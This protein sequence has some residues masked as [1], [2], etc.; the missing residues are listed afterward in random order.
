MWNRLKHHLLVIVV[1]IACVIA[2]SIVSVSKGTPGI[3]CIAS[4]VENIA[5]S[6]GTSIKSHCW[7]CANP[8]PV[9]IRL[10]VIKIFERA[11][12]ISGDRQRILICDFFPKQR[13]ANSLRM[14]RNISDVHNGQARVIPVIDII[15]CKVRRLRRC[16]I[17]INFPIQH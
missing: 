16:T 7:S 13:L 15:A 6:V 4:G 5:Q 14:R 12:G 11:S 1:I 8:A 17:L 2:F 3:A 10:K 9:G